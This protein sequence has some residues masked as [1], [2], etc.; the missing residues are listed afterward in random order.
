MQ[1]ATDP[2]AYNVAT[3]ITRLAWDV[4]LVLVPAMEAV[5]RRPDWPTPRRGLIVQR[6]TIRLAFIED[7]GTPKQTNKFSV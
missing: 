5:S 3:G 7:L 1:V 6:H 2:R 4:T